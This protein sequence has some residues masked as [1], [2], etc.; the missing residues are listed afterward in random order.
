MKSQSI[1]KI[2]SVFGFLA[3]AIGAFGAHGLEDLLMT[4]SRVETFETAVRYHFYH[5]LALLFCAGLIER[6]N[7]KYFTYSV[8]LFSIGII[9]FSGSLYILALT[10]MTILGAIT[11]LGGLC[12]LGG[13][14]SLFLASRVGK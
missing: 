7:P 11:P 2:A 14:S 10:N 4:N 13:W 8:Y 12:F 1:L 5:T 3:V 6:F 9:V